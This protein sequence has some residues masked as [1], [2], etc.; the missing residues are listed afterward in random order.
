[1]IGPA[2]ARRLKPLLDRLL[3]PAAM[4]ARVAFDPVRFAHR[5]ERPEDVELVALVSACLAYGRADLFGPR[6]EDLWRRVGPNPSAFARGLDPARERG[7]FEGLA[8]RFNTPADLAALVMVAGEAQASHGGLGALFAR[9]LEREGSLRPALSAFAADLRGR[10]RP[11]ALRPLGAMRGFGHLLPDPERGG[12]CKRLCLYLRWMVRGG[13]GDPIDLGIWPEVP[14]SALIVPLDT[15]VARIALCLGLTRRRDL[16]W[17]TA[18]DVTAS[19]RRLDPED[20]VRYDF[21]L[22]HHGMSGGCPRVRSKAACA[23]C[24]LAAECRPPRR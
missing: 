18:E 21:A 3:D 2:H 6:L 16:S 19:L 10:V 14:A 8:Y 17:A 22:C 23:A 12:A 1:M 15:H 11:K 13:P 4:R 24:A 7:A 5:Y 20:P 9:L